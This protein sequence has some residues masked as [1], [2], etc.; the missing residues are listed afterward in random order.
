[1]KNGYTIN[2]YGNGTYV[3]V[4]NYKGLNEI[5][6]FIYTDPLYPVSRSI[7]SIGLWKPKAKK[8]E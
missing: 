2:N 7:N 8:N 5:V 3:L 6:N 1:M 4:N